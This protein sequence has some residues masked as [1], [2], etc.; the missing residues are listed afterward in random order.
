[1]LHALVLAQLRNSQKLSL[2]ASVCGRLPLDSPGRSLG[3]LTRVVDGVIIRERLQDT[4]NRETHALRGGRHNAALAPP[5]KGGRGGTTV[6][7]PRLLPIIPMPHNNE[8]AAGA[9]ERVLA[10][11]NLAIAAAPP[12][13]TC[14]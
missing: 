11:I 12:A 9:A 14:R 5:G 6:R 8:A 4:R 10:G 7:S 3:H 2:V 13:P 1:M